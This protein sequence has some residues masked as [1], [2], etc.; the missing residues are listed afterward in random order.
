M[1]LELL[2]DWVWLQ[3]S[4][5]LKREQLARVQARKVRDTVR[6][7][8]AKVSFYHRLYGDYGVDV[9]SIVD[10]RSI[11]SLPTITKQDLQSTPLAQRTASDVDPGSCHV[12]TTSGSTGTPVTILQDDR[13][14]AY[15]AAMLLRI[16]WAHGIRLRHRACITVPGRTEASFFSV[17]KGLFGYVLNRKV[18]PLSLMLDLD[19]HMH[20]LSV[21]KPDALVAPV[22]YLRT[23]ASFCEEK[24]RSLPMKVIIA[25]SEMMDKPTKELIARTFRSDVFGW[26]GLSEV[27]G[28]AWECPTHAGYHINMDSFVAEFLRDGE[29][30]APSETGELCA[31]NLYNKAT[32]VIRYRTGD[33]A[34]SID[35][36]CECGRNLPLMK[37]IEGRV[38]DYIQTPNGRFVSPF[39]VMSVLETIPGIAQYKV[40]QRSDY[41]LEVVV[42]TNETKPDSLIQ[43]I[44]DRCVELF[45]KTPISVRIVDRIEHPKGGKFRVVESELRRVI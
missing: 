27:G 41:S 20:F 24:G 39:T 4:Q 34:A 13:V 19:E 40:T 15:R 22:S 7:A 38:V 32:P 1:M 28:V 35:D 2:K 14:I 11:T 12:R 16:L 10:A 29:E 21:L 6:H 44:Q 9:N 43:L 42:K 18:V 30:V 3:R 31:T 26:Y 25:M 23:L 8:F 45:E 37:S 33:M 17:S 36:E 5:W